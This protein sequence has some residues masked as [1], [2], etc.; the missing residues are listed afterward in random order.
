MLIQL[1]KQ[2]YAQ[3]LV[4]FAL[5]FLFSCKKDINNQNHNSE[6][7]DLTTKTNTSVSGFVTDENDQPV[8]GASVKAGT[9]NTTTNQFGYFELKNV[10]LVKTAAFVTIAKPGYFNATK[11]WGATENRT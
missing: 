1:R 11:T 7:P 10:E 4:I 2:W 6:A 5:L 9:A 3:M 8:N